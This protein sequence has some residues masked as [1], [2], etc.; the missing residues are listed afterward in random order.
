MLFGAGPEPRFFSLV[1]AH[2]MFKPSGAAASV[3]LNSL[4]LAAC[5]ERLLDLFWIFSVFTDG[6]A[7]AATAAS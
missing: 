6:L 2:E 3:K 4:S 5:L 1:L 7:A